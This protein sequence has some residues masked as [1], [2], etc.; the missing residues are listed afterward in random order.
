MN[1]S[2]KTSPCIFSFLRPLSFFLFLFLM[3]S[4]IAFA[5]SKDA[6]TATD[7]K[8]D[9]SSSVPLAEAPPEH[10]QESEKAPVEAKKPAKEKPNYVSDV[11]IRGNHIVS[12]NTVL[13]KIKSRKGDLLIQETV[14]DDVKR[15][16]ATG[17]FQD[18][19]M[20]VEEGRD[21]YVLI[22]EVIEKPIV[23][24]IVL[25]GFTIFKE[26][27]LR[28]ELKVIEGQIL[29]QKAI[30]QGDL[31]SHAQRRPAT[32]QAQQQGSISRAQLDQ[33]EWSRVE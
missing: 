12:T 13:S 9:A 24:Q 26:D 5:V 15:L 10:P 17:F 11:E 25:E 29:D 6:S 20:E 23:R 7:E 8:K 33:P 1:V 27:K 30:K 28:K 2:D 22:I 3:L 14:N 19:R 18:I 31:G 21:G 4:S 32:R 16:Y